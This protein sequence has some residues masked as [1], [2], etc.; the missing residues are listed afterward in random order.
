MS[1]HYSDLRPS[2]SASI[3]SRIAEQCKSKIL[4]FNDD[5]Y[6]Q[7]CTEKQ[8]EAF[9][10]CRNSNSIGTA[11]TKLGMTRAGIRKHISLIKAKAVKQGYSPEHD[12]INACPDGFRIKGTS[13]LY[14]DGKQSIQWVKTDVDSERRAQMFEEAVKAMCSDLPSIEATK[15][16]LI[17]NDDLMAIY[18][19]GD[20]H[21]GMMAWG[22]ESGDDWDLKIA[23]E[24]FCAVFDRLVKTSQPCAE[25][26]IV[27]LG[28]FFHADNME[29]QTSR[30]KHSLDMDG[31]YAK[32][33]A[34][35][36]KI[37]RQMITSAL[38]IHQKVRVINAVGNHDDT[39]SLFL[40][41]CLGNIYENEPRVTVDQ[42][43]AP[44]HY[45]RWGS[46]MFGVHHGH[47]CKA[48]RL[49]MVMATDQSKMWGETEFRTW[50]TGHIHHDTKKNILAVTLNHLEHWPLK[51]HTLRGEGIAQ[52]RIV[53]A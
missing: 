20:P 13:T 34:V 41:V 22:A 7:F 47:T 12:M 8:E 49:P 30:S 11:A 52:G 5:N 37:I 32:M 42:S 9:L 17:C 26:V 15:S 40:A 2:T 18:P 38:E 4:D 3:D 33:I 36:V 23:E 27:N 43:P 6:L 14:K 31:R 19:L 51:M 53:S 29:G 28:D 44:F 25:A 1:D 39:G 10:A 46:S 21:I 48:D 35:G 24:K 16:P 50:L 45:F